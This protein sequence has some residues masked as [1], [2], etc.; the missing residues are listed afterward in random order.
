M[1]LATISADK[2]IIWIFYFSPSLFLSFITTK[3]CTVLD[4][5]YVVLCA[6]QLGSH[7]IP[8]DICWK[9]IQALSAV[10]ISCHGYS[11]NASSTLN[12]ILLLKHLFL[13]E[14]G[15]SGQSGSHGH[16]GSTGIYS[17]CNTT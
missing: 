8:I 1:S 16:M 2:Y 9:K 17:Y 5:I 12:L 10:S 14:K 11:I 7:S 15:N 4:C 6:Y 13:G 3:K